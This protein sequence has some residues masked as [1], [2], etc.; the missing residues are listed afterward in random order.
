MNASIIVSKY[1][2]GF[3]IRHYIMCAQMRPLKRF[4]S[5]GH[6]DAMETQVL[7]I[8]TMVFCIIFLHFKF[9]VI[10]TF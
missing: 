3:I 1:A 6:V 7:N 8:C 10:V 5:T 4:L 2:L 9:P